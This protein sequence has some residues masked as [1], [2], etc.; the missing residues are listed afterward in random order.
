MTRKAFSMIELVIAVAVIGGLLVAALTAVG[1]SRG[2]QF[3]IARAR[4][5]RLLGDALLAEIMPLP[6]EDAD[7]PGAIGPETGEAFGGTREDFDDVDDL[8]GWSSATPELPDGTTLSQFSDY[9]RRVTV[10]YVSP[11]NLSQSSPVETGVKRITV[12]VEFQGG[13]VASRVGYRTRAK[14]AFVP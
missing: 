6:Y 7:N 1:A 3:K 12:T 9:V 2:S 14:D 8:D 11:I 10:E 13:Q 5:A 4:Q